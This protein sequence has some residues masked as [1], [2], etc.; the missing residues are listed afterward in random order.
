MKTVDIDFECQFLTN[1]ESDCIDFLICFWETTAPVHLHLFHLQWV[2][3]MAD[4]GAD[5]Y[6]FHYEAT[7]HP[8]RCIRKIKEAGMKVLR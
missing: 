7:P 8:E 1:D 2:E 4:A 6:T 3:H 5:M